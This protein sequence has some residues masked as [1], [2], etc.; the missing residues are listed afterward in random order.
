MPT[1]SKIFEHH[2]ATQIQD[3][4]QRTNVI[5]KTQSGFRKHHSCHTA[6]IRLVDTWIKEIDSGKLVGTVF[7]DLRKAFDLVDH[8]ILIYK[9]KLYHFSEQ[10]INLFKSYLTNRQ[11]MVKIGNVQ[12][13]ML[14]VKSG[15]PQGSI[16]GPLLFLLY[17]NAITFS[18]TQL[19]IDLYADDSTMFASGF[20]LSEIQVTLQTDLDSVEKWCILNNMSLHPK[21]SKCMTIGTRQRLQN[22]NQLTL[23]VNE[24]FLE[25]VTAQKVLGVFI[26][27]TLNWRSHIDYVC[28]KLNSK[29]Q[30]LKR[31]LYFLT[32]DMKSLFYN[33]YILPVFDYCCTIW[34][35]DNKS[36][37]N[38]I[39]NLKKELQN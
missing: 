23:K 22:I 21:K 18:C 30:L 14:I 19:N 7:L 2:I 16:L 13:E 37:I 5:H 33:S 10:S 36:Y 34:G 39:K 11:Q 25:N 15:V 27:N 17:I 20:K 1:I 12:S 24:T 28:K 29:I 8:E 31:V 26:D 3:Y 35:K 4:L 32:D 9:L 6:L 38:K